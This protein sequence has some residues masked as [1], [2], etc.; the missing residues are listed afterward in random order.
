M[1]TT[2]DWRR[3]ATAAVV[4]VASL[5]VFDRLISAAID[6][7][8]L[9]LER[10]AELPRKLSSL[11]N[12]PAYQWLILGT[13]RTFEAIHPA[14]LTGEFGVS[15][16]KEASK[17]KGLRYQAEFYRL[18]KQMVGTPRLV[19]VGLDY[20]M[21]GMESEPPLMRRFG[22]AVPG[23]E[24]APASWAPL[25]LVARKASTE[26]AVVR[27]LEGLQS[28]FVAS[29]DAFDPENRPADMLAYTGNRVSRVVEQ[30]EP[31]S[32][33]RV[34]YAPYPGREGK[35]FTRLVRDW[36]ADGTVV[37]L[38]YA[39]DYI[40]THRT[41]VE[42]G[43]FVEEIRRLVNGCGKCVVLDYD[44]PERFPL[45]EAGYFWDGGYGNPN[46]HLSKAGVEV[47]N[48]AWLRDLRDVVER[49]GLPVRRPA[50]T[51]AAR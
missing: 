35:Y 47:F 22:D 42:H 3:W 49:F 2:N 41:N 36:I 11:D 31:A 24:P 39:P 27:I 8:Y 6:G 44:D 16:F 50:A 26:R 38:V 20:F 21:F 17:G 45:S 33:E 9:R 10:H 4:F 23:V 37:V 48:R 19:I 18:Y 1:S 15:V 32:F 30:P 46:S 12:K 5:V 43:R 25:Q 40:A 7:L 28:R 13:S 29:M 51:S 14:F 34:P